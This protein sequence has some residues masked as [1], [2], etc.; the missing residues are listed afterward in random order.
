MLRN[1][2]ECNPVSTPTQQLISRDIRARQEIR[3]GTVLSA[4]RRLNFDPSA[5]TS[6]VYVVDVD[7]GGRRPIRNV[8]VKSVSGIGGRAYALPGKAVEI[9][10]NAGGRWI[11]IG[12]ADRVT[13]TGTVTVLDEA[14]GTT[15]VGVPIGFTSIPRFFDYWEAPENVWGKIGFG[16]TIIVDGDGNEVI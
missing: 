7:L 13:S 12:P 5:I 14:A 15:S 11:V 4:P 10:R 6:N 16:D 9:Q 8:P 2:D 3:R 1:D